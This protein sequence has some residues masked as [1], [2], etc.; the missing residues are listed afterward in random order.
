M[1]EQIY[2]FEREIKLLE[3][4]QHEIIQQLDRMRTG[5]QRDAVKD[6]NKMLDMLKVNRKAVEILKNNKDEF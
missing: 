6:Q 2:Y 1:D 4:R 5:G 3:K